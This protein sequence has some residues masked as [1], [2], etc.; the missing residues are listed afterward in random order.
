MHK[1]SQTGFP[2]HIWKTK[3]FLNLPTFSEPTS[4]IALKLLEEN[5]FSTCFP[6]LKR[7]FPDP[8]KNVKQIMSDRK[9]SIFRLRN[10][11]PKGKC[12]SSDVG[13]EG[14][15]RNHRVQIPPIPEMAIMI[16]ISAWLLGDPVERCWCRACCC[17]AA[18]PCNACSRE[19]LIY[20]VRWEHQHPHVPQ[21]GLGT[22]SVTQERKPR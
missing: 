14:W 6:S 5:D 10:R 3:T 12:N 17:G 9:E 21:T 1:G 4:C 7:L 16:C 11:N 8:F 13:M 20:A 18:V 15:D 19:E 2:S 22:W